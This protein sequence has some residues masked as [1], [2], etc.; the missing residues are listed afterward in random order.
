MGWKKV[1]GVDYLV[2]YHQGE[3]GNSYGRRSPE[4]DMTTS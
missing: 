3:D 4:T 2:R 1:K